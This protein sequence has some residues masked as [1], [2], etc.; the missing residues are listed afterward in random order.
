MKVILAGSGLLTGLL[1]AYPH[2]FIAI[3]VG[4]F[5]VW[6]MAGPVVAALREFRA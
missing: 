3:L 1:W 6:A 4:A 5:A 2:I